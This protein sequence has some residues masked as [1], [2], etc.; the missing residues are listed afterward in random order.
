MNILFI[1]N[2]LPEYRIKWFECIANNS[3]C[4][5]MF[6]NE[7]LNKKIY[8]TD[9]DYSKFKKNNY[10]FL[11]KGIQGYKEINNI[12][13]GKFDFI[14]FPPIDSLRELLISIYIYI[15]CKK[16]NIKTGY[17]WEKW[18]AP[19]E[20]QPM[21]RKV[22]NW[23]LKKCAGLIFKR[24]DIVFA[25]SSRSKQYFLDNG[26]DESKICIIPDVSEVP[27]CK[28][29]S[30]RKLYKIPEEKKIIL[31]FG[32]IIEQKGLDILIKAFSKLENNS[33]YYLLIVGDGAFKDYCEQ[34]AKTKGLQNITFTGAINPAD[35]KNFFEQCDIFVFPGT[36]RDGCVDVWGLT[37]N[38]AIQ[39]GKVV[40]STDAVGSAYDLIRDGINGYRIKP[41]NIE[42]LV[43][44]LKK[45]Q[46]NTIYDTARNIDKQ[47]CEY[48]SIQNMTMCYL[49]AIEKVLMRE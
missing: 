8:K 45:V 4:L 32:R 7:Q 9:I 3:N 37:I 23:I 36:F 5:F 16:R 31:Y 38:E 26:V 10:F 22:K 17:F 28:Y 14:E 1:H 49:K 15:I 30:I 25:G 6:T 41:E 47:L 42:D 11:N 29:E 27:D 24:V 20:L 12:I 43:W 21:K 33:N 46:N 2:T 19:Y 18:E 39:F 35:R 40:I 13:S 48:Y 44:A 34:L